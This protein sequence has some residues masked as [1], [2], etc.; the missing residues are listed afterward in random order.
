ML[1]SSIS[2]NYDMAKALT[3]IDGH[4]YV[5]YSSS[6]MVCQGPVRTLGTIDGKFGVDP[7]GLVGLHPRGIK[8]DKI[9]NIGWSSKYEQYGWT[10]AHTDATSEPF[11]RAFLSK[12]VL[13]ESPSAKPA[14]QPAAVSLAVPPP[15]ITAAQTKKP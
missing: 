11:V 15:A 8:T 10:G 14:T 4:V 12:H 1:G 7:T 3:N 13:P 2:S 5:Y 6:D 9:V